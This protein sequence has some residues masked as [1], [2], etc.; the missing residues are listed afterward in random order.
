MFQ[1]V[2][3]SRMSPRKKPNSKVQAE[4][5][6]KPSE[7]ARIDL[8]NPVLNLWILLIGAF[9]RWERIS[10]ERN[11]H[12][13][14]LKTTAKNAVSDRSLRKTRCFG[15]SKIGRLNFVA[16]IP[17]YFGKGVDVKGK[18]NVELRLRFASLF[19]N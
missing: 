11:S 5:R 13:R 2:L 9:R 16:E 17:K 7:A 15:G 10:I 18:R 3:R 6:S 12:H 1:T 14:L 8:E 4:N 19:E